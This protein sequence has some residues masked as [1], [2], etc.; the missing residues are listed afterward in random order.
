MSF[1]SDMEN[2]LFFY[3]FRQCK[4]NTNLNFLKL[5]ETDYLLFKFY[6]DGETVDLIHAKFET[7]ENPCSDEPYW[8]KSIR[9]SFNPTEDG[10]ILKETIEKL[11]TT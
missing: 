7:K 11:T 6:N 10:H 2:T 8:D 5:N 4:K 3:Q 9:L 1:Y